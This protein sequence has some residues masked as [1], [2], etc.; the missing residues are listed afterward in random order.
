LWN[1]PLD[2]RQADAV[3]TGPGRRY[4]RRVGYY[5]QRADLVALKTSEPCLS[6]APS[7]CLLETLRDLDIARRTHGPSNVHFRTKRG[8]HSWEPSFRF[9]DPKQIGPVHD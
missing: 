8:T 5:N 7:H 2:Q 9:A 4:R 3:A 6:E 1:L